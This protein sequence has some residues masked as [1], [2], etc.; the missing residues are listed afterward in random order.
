MGTLEHRTGKESGQEAEVI[1]QEPQD[2]IITCREF[3]FEDKKLVALTFDDGPLSPYTEQYLDIMARYGV[4]GTFFFL[5]DSVTANPDLARRVVAEGH[6]V[7][8]HTMAH[9]QLT[10]VDNETVFS[11]I[12]RSADVLQ[13]A[14]G[15]RST[16]LRPP[17]GDFTERSWLGTNGSISA[18]IRWT[19][20][21][22]DWRLP[23]AQAIVDKALLNVHSGSIILMHDGG[24]DRSQDV[25]ALP[26]LIERLQAEG[27]QFVTISDLMRAAG[28]IPEDVCSGT[29]TMPEGC[30]WPQEIHPDDI[31]ATGAV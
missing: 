30:V 21:S 31:A 10:S 26:M 25:E 8:N 4:K 5:G 2:C 18:A 23:G 24:G 22:E 20:D 15:I 3:L 13:A 11:E 12:S 29:A 7:A 1:T 27:Y 19:G 14:T 17:Y 28:D 6:Q 16:H 9:N